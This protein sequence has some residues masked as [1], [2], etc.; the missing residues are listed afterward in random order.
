MTEYYGDKRFLDYADTLKKIHSSKNHDY[1]DQSEPLS[2][3]RIVNE[4]VSGVP[5][6]PFKVAFTRLIEKVLRIAEVAKKGNKVADESIN[7][8]LIDSGVYSGLCKILIEEYGL[9]PDKKN[10]YIPEDYEPAYVRLRKSCR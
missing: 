1:A 5:D 3:F 10:P 7:D 2:N 9:N 4:I 6:S 8:S